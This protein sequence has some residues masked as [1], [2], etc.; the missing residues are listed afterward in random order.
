MV[1]EI[2]E[3]KTNV[4]SDILS[5]KF[6]VKRIVA[7]FMKCFQPSWLTLRHP[8]T[9]ETI[10]TAPWGCAGELPVKQH[11]ST[12]GRS[13]S[14]VW[15]RSCTPMHSPLID[16]KYLIE[17]DSVGIKH[18]QTHSRTLADSKNGVH[19]PPIKSQYLLL[20]LLIQVKANYVANLPQL[21]ACEMKKAIAFICFPPKYIC[22]S[23]VKIRRHG[24]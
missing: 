12:G 11:N 1:K 16:T 9:A 22:V 24:L 14:S 15:W 23:T 17:Q 6:T 21:S 5:V 4:T 10:K 20:M 2:M 19:W 18:W 3:S 8:F 13:H 7:I